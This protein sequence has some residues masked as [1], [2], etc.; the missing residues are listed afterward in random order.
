MYVGQGMAYREIVVHAKTVQSAGKLLKREY[1]EW[2]QVD[3][4]MVVSASPFLFA[5]RMHM[6]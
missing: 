6:E 5:G 1:P 4:W 2:T 3:K